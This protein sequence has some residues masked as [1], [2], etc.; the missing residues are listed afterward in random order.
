MAFQSDRE[1]NPDIWFANADGTD[2]T[3]YVVHP[4]EEVWSA[5]SPSGQWFYFTS[6]R[7]NVFNVWVKPTGEGQARQVT[8]YNSPAFGLPEN[9]LFTKF[10]VSNTVLVIPIETRKG[11][12]FILE[13]ED[14]TSSVTASR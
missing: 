8:S 9:N 12:I 7:S 13:M 10:A 3:P 1:G 2:P 4:A 5:W 11:D 14:H 6:N